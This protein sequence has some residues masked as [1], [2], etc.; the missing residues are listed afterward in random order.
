M[1]DH[2]LKFIISEC[3]QFSLVDGGSSRRQMIR[4]SGNPSDKIKKRKRK[5]AKASRRR[6]RL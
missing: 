6:N 1:N 5:I 2:I 3:E 4:K